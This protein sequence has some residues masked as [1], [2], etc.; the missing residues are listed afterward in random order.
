LLDV[1]GGCLP[2]HKKEAKILALL[3]RNAL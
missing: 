2:H 1:G 3:C